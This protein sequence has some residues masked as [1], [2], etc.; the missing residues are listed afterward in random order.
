MAEFTTVLPPTQTLRYEKIAK[1][2]TEALGEGLRTATLRKSESQESRFFR[3]SFA[4]RK[5]SRGETWVPH[6][7]L[8]ERRSHRRTPWK[9]YGERV[10]R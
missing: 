3:K 4:E 10:W 9:E 6:V 8:F 7:V 2:T 1:L 5:Q